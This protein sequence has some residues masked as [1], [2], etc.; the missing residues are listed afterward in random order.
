MAVWQDRG[1]GSAWQDLNI[2]E[3]GEEVLGDTS[4]RVCVTAGTSGA[5]E[6]DWTD[7]DPIAD[8]TVE[9]EVMDSWQADTVYP[10][11]AHVQPTTPTTRFYERRPGNGLSG[12]VEPTWPTDD[13]TVD[14]ADTG[15]GGVSDGALA[16]DVWRIVPPGTSYEFVATLDDASGKSIRPELNGTGSGQFDIS[17]QSPHATTDVVAMGNLVKVRI[18][19][20]SE[21]YLFSFFME[22]GDFDLISRDEEGGEALH[23]GGRGGLAYWDRAIWLSET[24]SIPWWP[25]CAD[26]PMPAGAKGVVE[27]QAGKYR[28]YTVDEGE[29]PPIILSYTNVNFEDD[30]CAWFDSRRTY[31]WP[32][33][34]SKRFLVQLLDGPHAGSYFHPHQD[35]VTE[36]LPSGSAGYKSGV[37]LSDVASSP[38]GVIDY[39]FNEGTAADRPVQPIPLMSVDFDASFDS[40]SNAWTTSDAL[41]GLSAGIGD[42]YLNTIGQVLST[43]VVDV[44][45]GPDLDM[46]GYNHYGTDRTGGAFAAG[47]VRFVKGVN[48]AEALNEAKADGPIAT[49]AEVA[50]NDDVYVQAIIPSASS[51]VAREMSVSGATDDE[52]ALEQIG[53]DALDLTRARSEAL[54]FPVTVGDDELVGLYLPAPATLNGHYWLGDDV[55]MHTGSEDTDLDN[56]DVRVTAIT[57]TEDDAGNLLAVPEVRTGPLPITGSLNV[58]TP[59]AVATSSECNCPCDLGT[60]Y[61]LEE[62]T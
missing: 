11:G 35:G 9:W 50:G 38:G 25:D 54:A 30:W 33:A 27:V 19:A 55:T 22:Q 2:Y 39:L 41:A 1:V 56:L 31:Q 51:F 57:L 5:S 14:D 45:M 21:E 6:P 47:V 61:P 58:N 36:H 15:L 62:E 44:V 24:F 26:E 53:L 8:G 10:L 49:F 48:I 13:G 60:P 16:F 34:N 29:T 32:S 40:D 28:V 18:P 7:P 43:G 20:I 23:F 59:D 12:S 3:L 46:H 4:V 17:R 42:Y 52:A 37:V